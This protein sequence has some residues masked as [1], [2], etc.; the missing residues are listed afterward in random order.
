M[1]ISVAPPSPQCSNLRIGPQLP[2]HIVTA[3]SEDDASD[4][5][6][7]H[8]LDENRATLLSA[9]EGHLLGG[10]YVDERVIVLRPQR[11]SARRQ[12]L[13]RGSGLCRPSYLAQ[14]LIMV[15]AHRSADATCCLLKRKARCVR[16]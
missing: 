2:L 6:G 11:R 1:Q 12:W 5:A 7:L 9:C 14:P 13:A 3:R 10:G 15:G 4:A 16:G 8:E